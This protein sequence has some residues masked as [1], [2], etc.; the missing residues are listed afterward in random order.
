M[1]ERKMTR[2]DVLIVDDEQDFREIMV[3]KLSKRDLSCDSAAD[4]ITALEMIKTKNYDVVLLDVK[5][6]S[7]NFV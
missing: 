6:P 2:Y 7:Y 4:G 3:K 5:M 1:R